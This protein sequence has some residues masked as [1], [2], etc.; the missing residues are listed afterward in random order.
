MA[1]DIRPL[2]AQDQGPA[3]ALGSLAFGYRDRTMPDDWSSDSPGRHTWG[4][5]VDGRLMA[6][7]VDREQSHWFGGRLVPGSGVAGVAV[8]PELRGQGLARTVLTRLLAGVRDRGGWLS[9]LFPT[10]PFPYRSVGFEQCGVL[11]RLAVPTANL[12]GIGIPAGVRVRPAEAADVPVLAELFRSL[13]REGT[14]VM[15]RSGAPWQQLDYLAEYDGVSVVE[16]DRTV[17]GYAS[18]DRGNGSDASGRVMVDDLVA[19][20]AAG[21]QALLSMLA[22]W[23]PVAPTIALRSS[24]PDPV[25]LLTSV[26]HAPV[27]D[28]RPWMLRLVDAAAAIAARGWPPELTGSVDLDLVDAECPWNAG[29]YRLVLAGGEGRLEPGGSG[30]IGFAPRGL[31]AWYAGAATPAVLRR[32]GL[33]AGGDA[34]GESLLRAASAGPPPQLLDYF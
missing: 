26:G 24:G 1:V 31:A 5:F 23:A 16:D 12:A 11:T 30:T 6:K 18:W 25:Q 13:A 10:T 3:W 22:S 20:S 27:H 9:T 33:F 7:A 34:A 17:I 29:R 28:G 19:T 4:G 14:A 15:D 2:T 21:T 8:A 32:A